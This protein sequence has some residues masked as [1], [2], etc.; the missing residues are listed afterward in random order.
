MAGMDPKA[1]HT[2]VRERHFNCPTCGGPM[3]FRVESFGHP[4]VR[5]F[6]RLLR[7]LGDRFGLRLVPVEDAAEALIDGSASLYDWKE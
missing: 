3:L 1:A 2:V 4:D 6:A 7:V 5:E